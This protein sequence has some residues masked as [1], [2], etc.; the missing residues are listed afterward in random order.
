MNAPNPLP[1]LGPV[2]NAAPVNLGQTPAGPES[3]FADSLSLALSGAFVQ[4]VVPLPNPATG[5]LAL[6][7]D[8]PIETGGS[9]ILLSQSSLDLAVPP[10]GFEGAAGGISLE[11]ITAGIDSQAKESLLAL[12]ASTS[13]NTDSTV[14]AAAINLAKDQQGDTNSPIQ[15]SVSSRPL[16]GTSQSEVVIDEKGGLSTKALFDADGHGLPEQALPQ[17]RQNSP[18][19]TERQLAGDTIGVVKE[20]N[21]GS[22]A[23]FLKTTGNL[24]NKP[25]S[26]QRGQQPNPQSL[27]AQHGQG[28]ALGDERLSNAEHLAHVRGQIANLQTVG[29]NLEP[30]KPATFAAIQNANATEA[31]RIDSRPDAGPI[32]IFTAEPGRIEPVGSSNAKPLI[33]QAQLPAMQIALQVTRAIPQ[34]IDRFSLQLHPTELGTVEIQ[35]DFAEDGRVS[36]LIVAELPETLD[37]LQRDSRSL[38][39]SLN[40]TGLQL[41][42]GGLSFSLKQDQDQQGQGFGAF[43]HHQSPAYRNGHVLEGDGDSASKQD[44]ARITQQRLLDIHT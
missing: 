34:G 41:D 19:R 26:D 16:D 27:L 4:P 30:I 35:L 17:L 1:L 5:A 39:R 23:E 24:H 22:L 31:Q 33:Q 7:A 18:T 13:K 36:A 25:S 2:G 20:A 6:L 29:N 21:Q 44:P 28:T 43:S 15:P 32:E 37:M 9:E 10:A 11:L 3:A 40:D 42:S 12:P 14:S 8:A 38:E